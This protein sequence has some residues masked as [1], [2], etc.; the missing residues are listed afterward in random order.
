MIAEELEQVA[1]QIIRTRLGHRV[2]RGPRV[3]AVLGG[4]AARGNLELLQRIRERQRQA[5]GVGRAVVH[6]AIEEVSHAE[7]LA[8]GDGDEDA[9]L[10]APPLRLANARRVLKASVEFDAQAAR[11]LPAAEHLIAFNG[12]ALAQFGAARRGG[13]QSLSLVSATS[14]LR[15]VLR[16]YARAYKQYPL[17]G[18]WAPRVAK[19]TLLEYRQ[20]DRIYV[21]S[22]HARQ[23]FLEEGI[24]EHLLATFPL[25]PA[26]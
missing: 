7:A 22:P 2:D 19:R 12:T 8:S 10:E 21:S 20:A 3:N 4:Q 11:R 25:T 17:E 6:G 9:A 15:C 26:A 5:A 16:Q 24:G 13:F 14:H 1:P 18:S 23:S